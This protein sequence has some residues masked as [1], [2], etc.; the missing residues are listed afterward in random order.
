MVVN[1]PQFSTYLAEVARGATLGIAIDGKP[2]QPASALFASESPSAIFPECQFKKDLGGGTWLRWQAFAPLSPA[3]ADVGFLP[4]LIG[5]A[6]LE[7]APRAPLF[8]RNVTISYRLWC[9]DDAGSRAA[10]GTRAAEPAEGYF[11][12]QNGAANASTPLFVGVSGGAERGSDCG[13]LGEYD[14]RGRPTLCAALTVEVSPHNRESEGLL[15]IGY[16]NAAGRHASNRRHG[17]EFRDAEEAVE[18]T[19]RPRELILTARALFER[20]ERDAAV[21]SAEHASFLATIPQSHDATTDAAVR[22]WLQAS[23]LLTKG[24]GDRVLTMGYVEL[25][26]RDSFWTASLHAYVWPQLEAMMLRESC[27]FQCGDGGGPPSYCQA[28]ADGVSVD[29]KIPTTILPTI[30]RD[31]NID[32]TAFFV[33]RLGRYVAATGDE[34]LLADLFPCLRRALHY[35]QRRSAPGEALPAA[36]EESYW[37]SW[38]DVPF[39]KGRKLMVDNSVLYLA[40]LRTGAQAASLLA[41]RTDARESRNTFREDVNNF[42]Y[43]YSQ[44][45]AQLVAPLAE[46]GLWDADAQFLRDTWWSGLTSNYSLGDVFMSVYFRLL[47]ESRAKA[48]LHHFFSAGLEGEFG[49]R[50]LW[51]YMPHATDPSGGEYGPGIYANGGSYAWMTCGTALAAF[52]AGDTESAWRLWSKHSKQMLFADG[53]RRVPYEY[54]HSETGAQMGNAPQGWS[55]VCAAF[56]W[57]GPIVGWARDTPLWITGAPPANDPHELSL[58]EPEAA[59]RHTYRLTSKM[60]TASNILLPLGSIPGAFA[61]IGW[62]TSGAAPIIDVVSQVK[63]GAD[64][65][66]YEW[67]SVVPCTARDGVF[68]C[69]AS[70]EIRIVI[71]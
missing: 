46:G 24:I 38:L 18:V 44:G 33:M 21:L 69:R 7:L 28:Y 61:R 40:S 39:L 6:S 68:V 50:A 17:P 27:E 67:R 65:G 4:L 12:S 52:F 64:R 63:G 26:Q 34:A 49:V 35:L 36:R 51:P 9:G 58:I 11:Y 62:S 19:T 13:V 43:A 42:S 53:N 16:H 20:A 30:L 56:A 48:V 1:P 14:E 45:Y 47:G 57:S 23:I 59:H 32:I 5:R 71:E 2:M 31:D 8:S 41:S 54:L 60:S 22:W 25:N 66:S 15:V 55:S 10:C 29:G 70:E 37:G 3:D